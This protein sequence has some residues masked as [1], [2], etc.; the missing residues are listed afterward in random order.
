LSSI[1]THAYL[2]WLW[3]IL[4]KGSSIHF[5]LST[6]FL[7]SIITPRDQNR[8]VFCYNLF[9]DLRCRCQIFCD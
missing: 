5:E 6:I 7:N 4:P 3:T 2:A 1:A 8:D 9:L